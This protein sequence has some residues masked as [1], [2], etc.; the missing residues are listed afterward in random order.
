MSSIKH[1]N[2]I[3]EKFVTFVLKSLYRIKSSIFQQLPNKNILFST[4][5]FKSNKSIHL[6]STNPKRL[7]AL[8]I[9]TLLLRIIPERKIV[10]GILGMATSSFL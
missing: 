3:A 2:S 10:S 1:Q 7:N 9:R 4:N 5:A 6:L 8:Y